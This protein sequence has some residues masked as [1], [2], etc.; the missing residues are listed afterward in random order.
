MPTYHGI[1]CKWGS[2]HRAVYEPNRPFF[3]QFAGILNI[4]ASITH[5][6]YPHDLFDRFHLDSPASCLHPQLFQLSMLGVCYKISSEIGFPCQTSA[7][8]NEL[9]TNLMHWFSTMV[10]YSILKWSFTQ[11]SEEVHACLHVMV[12]CYC[13]LCC[14]SCVEAGATESGDKRKRVKEV[15]CVKMSE[16]CWMG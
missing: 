9:S 16:A 8:V 6:E 15:R 10:Q 11:R 7:V 14:A 3:F 2:D 12:S 4:R 5:R 13:L 1:R